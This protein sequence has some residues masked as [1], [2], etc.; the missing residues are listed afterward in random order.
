[1]T[2]EEEMKYT[3]DMARAQVKYEM[4]NGGNRDEVEVPMDETGTLL[5]DGE[6]IENMGN[7][8][9]AELEKDVA[10]FQALSNSGD[11]GDNNETME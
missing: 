6:E 8:L 5:L 4:E 7:D 11:D 3:A 9:V 2:R 1:M 10:E